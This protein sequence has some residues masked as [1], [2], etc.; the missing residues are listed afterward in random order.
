MRFVVGITVMVGVRTEAA[1]LRHGNRN[2][3]CAVTV[4][5]NLKRLRMAA[6]GCVLFSCS[7]QYVLEISF[8]FELPNP[9]VM[10]IPWTFIITTKKPSTVVSY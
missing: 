7:W 5:D 8:N 4:A 9:V 6:V 10:Y 3:C 1:G 2:F